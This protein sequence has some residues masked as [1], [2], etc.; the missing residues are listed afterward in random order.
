MDANVMF[1]LLAGVMMAVV[2]ALLLLP[3]LRR[4][5]RALARA[6]YDLAVYRDQLRELEQEVEQG[7]IGKE[8]AERA[9]NAI[10]RR[11]L[12]ADKARQ[13]A[14]AQV[15]GAGRG[16]VLAAIG[17]T[18]LVPVAALAFYLNTGEPGRPDMPL[19]QRLANAA[20]NN[21][22]AALVK[23]AEQ[24][25]ATNPDDLRG[26]LA[27]AP[28]YEQLGRMDKAVEAWRKAIELSEKPD[29]DLYNSYAEALVRA[30]QGRIPDQAVRA[31][32]KALDLAPGNPMSRYYLAMADLQAGRRE[33][34]YD[35]LKKLLDDL[36][37]DV[38]AR[39]TI[40][41]QVQQ[42]G[43]MLGKAPG[44][45][46][47][48]PVAMA[49]QASSSSSASSAPAS[50]AGAAGGPSADAVRERMRAMQNASPQERMAMIRNMVESL[51]A[52]LQ[53]DPDDLGGWLRLIRARKVLGEDDK[54]RAALKR[55]NEVF[56]NDE[57]ARRK[58]EVLAA[59]I[60]IA[61]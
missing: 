36:P 4:P 2:L 45:L 19:Q 48:G 20:Q 35:A 1:W 47:S 58:L 15:D 6:E 37:Q 16:G 21:D 27:L 59:Q 42:L 51:D 17:A 61:P 53:E 25:L 26:W 9:R 11:I 54:A 38:P 52:R 23:R 57:E 28:A 40:A 33:Q 32:R 50:E 18:L 44:S 29:A 8:E 7:L 14:Q 41:Q 12:A 13:Q 39:R 46:P 55:A 31:F 10:A 60:G 43:M 49:A 3:L 5:G 34:A 22:L 24:R 30:S 56:A